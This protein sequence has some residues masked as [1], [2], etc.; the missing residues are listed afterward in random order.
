MKFKAVIF[1]LDGTLLDT[2][3]DLSDS[4]NR[5]LQDLKFPGH[6]LEAVKT[7]VGHGIRKLARCAL[8]ENARDE[9]TTGRCVQLIKGNYKDTWKNTTRPFDGVPEMLDAVSNTEIKMGILSNKVDKY[10][11]IIVQD[12]LSKWDFDAVQGEKPSVPA[13]PDPAGALE[14]ARG[15]SID[16]AEI[17][18]LGDMDTD[19]ETAVNAGM[20]PVGVLW[21]YHS[22]EK[23]QAARAKRIIKTPMELLEI[24]S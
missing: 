22:K 9:E 4:V 1:D 12:L 21:G 24:L 8:P 15:M 16:P 17:I 10:T 23:L 5:A 20:Y 19:V 2:I 7:F 13:K 18:F 11:Q 6:D 3:Q 14:M